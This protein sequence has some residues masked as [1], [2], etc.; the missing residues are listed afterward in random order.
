MASENKLKILVKLPSRERPKKFEDVIKRYIMMSKDKE[1]IHYL[2]SLDKNDPTLQQYLTLIESIKANI[3]FVV[4]ESTGKI[5]ACNRDIDKVMQWD[6]LVLASDDMICQRIG[7]DET[8][9]TEMEAIFPE[10]DGILFH[11][12][13]YLGQRL[14][15]MC[16]LGRKR[17]KK[18]GYIY[19][20]EYTSL[21]CD[22]EFMEVGYRDGKQAYFE[23]CLFKHE[24]YSNGP[25]HHHTQDNLLRRNEKYFAQ[26]KKVYERRKAE[27]FPIERTKLINNE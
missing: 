5:D 17:Y 27:G 18:F 3:T 7:W 10:K 8:L 6:I 24:H 16:I 12:D 2:I 20:P 23:E 22:N 15:T 21:W 25:Q 14:N 19:N 1:N 11:N 13:G 9:R 4:G 26:D